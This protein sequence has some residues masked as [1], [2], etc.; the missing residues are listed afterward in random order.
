MSNRPITIV[1]AGAI[2]GVIG[3]ALAHGGED[4]TLVDVD[5]DHVAAIQERGLIVTGAHG[6]SAVA[7]KA[8]HP[9]EL[10]SEAQLDIV[11]LSVKA[12]HTDEAMRTIAP[13]LGP[14]GF[15]VS[16]Q[17]GLQEPVI[18]RHIGAARTVGAFVNI[19]ADRSE[20]GEIAYGGPGTFVI[21]EIDGSDSRR[22]DDLVKRLQVWGPARASTNVNGYL[23]SKLAYG[24]IL[25]A[26]ATTNET[27]ADILADQQLRP[28]LFALASEVLTIAD[29]HGVQPQPFDDWDPGL[30]HG[31]RADQVE[32][33]A[34]FDRLVAR[35]RNYTKTRT[36]VWRDLSVH[37]RR[38]EVPIHYAPV[39][40]DAESF[41]VEVPRIR[42]LVETIVGIENGELEQGLA[43]LEGLVGRSR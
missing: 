31:S 14:T 1:G 8:L 6:S 33:H 37:R 19:Y 36:G 25:I 28:A 17:N 15:V 38:T 27:I 4:V 22:V 39:V 43:N 24:A 23:W 3:H 9:R 34:M 41:G 5:R 18:A 16:V 12:L 10:E 42:W 20:P 7:I 30:V 13:R 32:A 40:A 35:L 29:K 11:L 26:T 2:G 21:G